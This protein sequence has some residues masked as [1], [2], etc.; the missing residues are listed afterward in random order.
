MGGTI[1][2]LKANPVSHLTTQKFQVN[3]FWHPE[4]FQKL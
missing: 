2:E 4:V 1:R 3:V